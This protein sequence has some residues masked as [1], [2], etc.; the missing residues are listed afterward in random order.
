[1][2]ISYCHLMDVNVA[3]ESCFCEAKWRPLVFTEG[4]CML[5]VLENEIIYFKM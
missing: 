2:Q 4:S 5:L 3:T 1:M